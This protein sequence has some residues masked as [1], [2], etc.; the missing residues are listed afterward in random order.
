MG[1]IIDLERKEYVY[2]CNSVKLGIVW[3]NL[4][5]PPISLIFLIFGII[6]MVLVK[7]RKT[8]LTNIILLIFSSEII[9]CLSKL[10]QLLKY[11][12][13]DKRDDKS[14]KDG[15]TPRGVICQIQI[16][17][18]IFSDFCSLL[19]T[20]LLS[21]RYYDVIKN[22]K[23]F[24]DKGK[25][26]IISIIFFLILSF[27]L[28]LA[29]LFIDK[30]KTY[31][32]VS[33]RYDL[34]DRCSYWCWLEHLPSL[35]CLGLY[36]IILIFNIYFACKTN[37]YLK[38]GY[39]KLKEDNEY[40]PGKVNDM[41]EPLNEENN[42]NILKDKNSQNEEEKKVIH[43]TN[44]EKKRIEQIK[45]MRLKCQIYPVVTICY[46]A[47]AAT[48]RIVDDSFMWQFDSSNGDPYE[49]EERERELFNDYPAFHFLVQFFFVAYTFFS[50]I[51]GI[52]YGFSFI[53][54]EEKIF[55]NFFKRCFKRC[56]KENGF[57]EDEEDENR[58]VRTT[59]STSITDMYRSRGKE[60]QK[61]ESTYQ[62]IEM[63][64]NNEYN[65]K[66]NE[67]ENDNNENQ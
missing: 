51:R 52:L 66:E 41:N 58:L 20:L 40:L 13:E 37:S 3:I 54:F 53:V 21:L 36:W 35:I 49:Q 57:E 17:T 48:Y 6:R 8:F 26:G 39:K 14:I 60:D 63:R 42:D 10:I 23:R 29:F 11:I 34:R 31:N 16:T 32:N 19:N 1:N 22:K 38:S 7:K 4:I 28:A 59:N 30:K 65:E 46:W 47:F 67:N 18:A 12:Y 44:E 15:N 61:D 50:S 33:Y 62:N 25:N 45:L 56:Y 55:F 27:I 64:A 5:G 9:Q 24:F 43:L 2:R